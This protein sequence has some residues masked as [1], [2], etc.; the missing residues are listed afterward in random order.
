[1]ATSFFEKMSD[2]LYECNWHELPIEMQKPL[3]LM[4]QN[5]QKP[6][7]F[8]GFEVILLKLETFCEVS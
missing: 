3:I 5:T 1:M 8:S 4:I 7:Y 6:I 2:S